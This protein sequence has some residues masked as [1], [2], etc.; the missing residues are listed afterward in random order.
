MARRGI[1]VHLGY[2]TDKYPYSDNLNFDILR[3]CHE[4]EGP[5]LQ[6][7]AKCHYASQF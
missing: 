7:R 3:Y 6:C 5:R 1:H 2:T 4:F